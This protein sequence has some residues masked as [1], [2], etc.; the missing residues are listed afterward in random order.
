MAYD[1]PEYFHLGESEDSDLQVRF[2]SLL[3]VAGL[4][5]PSA[6]ASVAPTVIGA[7][8]D[9][10]DAKRRR[11]SSPGEHGLG[12]LASGCC[13]RCVSTWRNSSGMSRRPSR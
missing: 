12:E 3:T 13:F 11:S 6:L 5:L 1:V 8:G 7:T 9:R 2:V 10:T 4:A